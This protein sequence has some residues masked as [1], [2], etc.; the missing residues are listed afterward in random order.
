MERVNLVRS[1]L[2]LI[3][4]S[5]RLVN[6]P[7]LVVLTNIRGKALN[8]SR[9]MN[10]TQCQTRCV[11]QTVVTEGLS[12]V[13]VERL[14]C[15]AMDTE[16][17]VANSWSHNRRQSPPPQTCMP[18]SVDQRRAKWAPVVDVCLIVIKWK[19]S[20]C[21]VTNRHTRKYKAYW[22]TIPFMRLFWNQ[23]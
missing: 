20:E 12:W 19:V 17:D 2:L 14:A 7:L 21:K 16:T 5:Y 9:L 13:S 8:H 15:M 3:E 1:W 23:T 22:T 11:L 18:R 10:V 4:E 6:L